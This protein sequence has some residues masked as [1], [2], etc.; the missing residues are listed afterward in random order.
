MGKLEPTLIYCPSVECVG[1]PTKSCNR[2]TGVSTIEFPHPG[3]RMPYGTTQQTTH[4]LRNQLRIGNLSPNINGAACTKGRGVTPTIGS[5]LS[6]VYHKWVMESWLKSLWKKASKFNT[7]VP[8]SPP[9]TFPWENDNWLMLATKVVG[10]NGEEMIV[11]LNR[12]H[13]H[14]QVLCQTSLMQMQVGK[15]LTRGHDT[16]EFRVAGIV[17]FSNNK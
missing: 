14:Q 8:L 5:Q 15:L 6:Q 17:C 9:A 1:S 13:S 16:C 12:I 10:Y 3:G 4:V 7:S 2:W 11:W